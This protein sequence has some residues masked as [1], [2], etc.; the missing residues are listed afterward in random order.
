MGILL[1]VEDGKIIG[2]LVEGKRKWNLHWGPIWVGD[3]TPTEVLE[4]YVFI[5]TPSTQRKML[6]WP[7]TCM[8][9]TTWDCKFFVFQWWGDYSWIGTDLFKGVIYQLVKY[10]RVDME[11]KNGVECNEMG[12]WGLEVW[13]SIHKN[14]V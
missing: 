8:S 9:I 10:L 4:F 1:S 13:L 12:H 5:Y 11:I 6:S 7:Y 3:E 14:L 2:W